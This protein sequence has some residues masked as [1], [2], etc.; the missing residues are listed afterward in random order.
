MHIEA[1]ELDLGIRKSYQ[2][3]KVFAVFFSDKLIVIFWPCN[4][5]LIYQ[6]I[7]L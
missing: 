3:Y 1:I 7:K 5:F 6:L 4:I 2:T